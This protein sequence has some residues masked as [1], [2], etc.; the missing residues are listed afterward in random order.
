[1]EN[2][3]QELTGGKKWAG[4]GRTSL[5]QG[6]LFKVS[7]EDPEQEIQ[8][9]HAYAA[10]K[11]IPFEEWCVKYAICHHCR[12]KG[13]IRPECKKFR[14]DVISL[15]HQPRDNCQCGVQE[16][17][18]RKIP[19]RRISTKI[20][21]QKPSYLLLQCSLQETQAL[22]MTKMSNPPPDEE[23]NNH[24]PTKDQ[25]AFLSMVGSLKE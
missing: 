24:K 9:A 11:K 5:L 2:K 14:A 18:G 15:N 20:Q 22:I 4:V 12:K 25:L 16:D 8:E 13:Q 6:S 7:T 21:K 1:M 19:L 3:Y 17:Y 23:R 10:I